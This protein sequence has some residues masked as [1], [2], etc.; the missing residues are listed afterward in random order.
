MRKHFLTASIIILTLCIAG[1]TLAFN[2]NQQAY[3]LG[4]PG[5]ELIYDVD[6]HSKPE[7]IVERFSL[8][9]GSV[10]NWHD[11]DFQWLFL[12]IK[13]VNSENFTIAMLCSEYPKSSRTTSEQLILRYLLSCETETIEYHDKNNGNAELPSTGAWKYLIPGIHENTNPFLQE[14]HKLILLG[15]S[16]NLKEKRETTM[17]VAPSPSTIVDLTPDLR[18][19]V[20]HNTKIKN[21]VRR[22]D[23]SDY[24]YVAL[25]RENY[26]EMINHGMNVFCVNMKQLPWIQN[27]D[28]YYW[29]PTGKDLNYPKDLY[30]S[31]YLGPA[32]FFDEP[33]VH[34]RDRAL[35]PK[36]KTNPELRK[37][38]TPK[39]YFEEFKHEY[40]KAKYERSAVQLSKGLSERKDVNT[41]NMSF[42]QENVYS[43]ETMV[44]SALYQLSEG[45]DQTPSA[46]VFEPPGR[47]G[48]KRVLP[49]LN[50]CFDCQIPVENPQNLI[51]II[52]GFLRGAAR[53]TDKEWGISI[54]GQV[55]RSEAYWYMTHTYNQG[56]TH[57][58]YWDTYQLA[59]VPYREYLKL[60]Q[61]L[62]TYAQNHPHRD[63]AKLKRRAH[64]AIVLPVGYNLGHVKMGIGNIGGLPELNMERI[65]KAGV[66]Y[67]K[68]MSN[69]LIEIERCIRSGIA[70]DL[71]WDLEN[72]E[73]S[74]YM[75][76]VRIREDGKIEI[77]NDEKTELLDAARV[78]ERPSGEAPELTA[79]V[80]QGD[81][82]GNYT[83]TA[84]VTEK[85]APV[86]YTQGADSTGINHN[87]YVLWELYGPEEEDY[88]DFW[89]ERWK[90]QT[91]QKEDTATATIN[92]RI[93]KP[94]KYRL[95]VST[96]DLEGRSTVVWKEIN[97]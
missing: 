84:K 71:Y 59:A 95:R 51:G 60:S 27:Q 8:K 39:G 74:E 57:F 29:G 65:N 49:E 67:R 36:F 89:Q 48:A 13:K 4:K 10:E 63:L 97:R 19:G 30:R 20:P 90:I 1:V 14:V 77:G 50:M 9:L 69:F 94:G 33:M 46:I 34:T 79:S 64:T 31:N 5:T 22:Y 86:Y 78:P 88:T 28:V 45:G 56:A 11:K 70:Y 16:Y 21:E 76:V 15:L 82:R 26:M 81:E 38:I 75:E 93:S 17:P 83:A 44:S 6:L 2:N 53:Q 12:D 40:H 87:T 62:R 72:I 68:V 3:P 37:T 66:P 96:C 85:S 55:D 18:I 23:E 58:Y 47:F 91:S 80:K 24:E 54:Y 92:F 43:W 35:K 52:Q 61:N 7:S 42:L 41:G 25:K 73:T 32:I